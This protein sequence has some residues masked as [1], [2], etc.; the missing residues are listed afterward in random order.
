MIFSR[1]AKN[2][3]NNKITKQ[4]LKDFFTDFAILTVAC[5]ISSFSIVSVMIPN[6]LTSGGITGIVRIVQ[7]FVDV[8]F[9]ILYYGGTLIVLVLV[10]VFMGWKELRKI[11]MLSILYPAVLFIF[12]KI[13]FQLLE[14]KDIILAAVFCGVFSGT[15][16]GLVFWRGYASAGSD[17]I[18]KIIRK[19]LFPDIGLSKILLCVDAIIVISSAFVYGRNIAMYALITQV[20]ISK[21]SETIMYGF[22]S[23]VV[24][25][26]IITSKYE[27][28]RDYVLMDLERGVSSI[29]IMG[30]YT[31]TELKQ[32]TVMCSVRESNL[33]RKKIAIMDPH[34]FVTVTKLEAVWGHGK[35]FG[36]LDKE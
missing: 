14:E 28:I 30:E 19:K 34:A 24:Q 36:D 35:G 11:L 7:N 6:G 31:Q 13:N 26:T 20:I 3:K 1:K 4:N 25:L 9:S 18:A 5:C 17:A 16:V 21:M 10:A 2:S 12:E 32:L 22:A 29:D 23:K 15:Y 27:G 33:I 8:D